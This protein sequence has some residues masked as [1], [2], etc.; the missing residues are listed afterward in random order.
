MKRE[1]L[2][3]GQILPGKGIGNLREAE[4]KG[5]DMRKMGNMAVV[6]FERE[7][8][9]CRG[10][11]IRNPGGLRIRRNRSPEDGGDHHLRE[12]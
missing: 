1:S 5:D 2:G 3:G 11:T 9:K 12:S 8:E 6:R 10:G 4:E 7:Y